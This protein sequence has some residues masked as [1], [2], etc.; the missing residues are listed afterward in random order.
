MRLQKEDIHLLGRHSNLSEEQIKKLL[1]ENVY[2]GKNAWQQFIKLFFISL[3][4]GFTAAGIVFFFAYNWADIHKFVKF[5]IIEV[6][7][8]ALAGI[9]ISSKANI[10]GKNILL[11]GLSI[12]VGVMFAVFGQ[13]Y[14]TGANAFDF[15][16]GWTLCILLWVI[17]SR[18]APLWLLFL[19][20]VSTTFILYANQ[21]ASGWSFVF[22]SGCLFYFNSVILLAGMFIASRKPAFLMPKWF[23][24]V[25]SLACIAFST[26]SIVIGIFEDFQ[27]VWL[28][29]LLIACMLYTA[30]V[31]Y[32]L[33]LKSG[34]Y[35]ALTSFSTIIIISAILINMTDNEPIGMFLLVSVFIVVSITL[36][37]RTLLNL[38]KK[39]SHEI[40]R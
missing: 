35:I 33:K 12:I 37:I 23:Q 27:L 15:F 2:A 29:T 31:L 36:V 10:L 16:L 5:A 17:I 19:T 18:F 14:Q 8:L 13:V 21:V 1:N 7:I 26:I 4:V 24:N 40:A 30:A 20:L 32:S 11:T 39:W 22:V 25:L 6:L 34:F 3:G 9:I 38:Q 28:I